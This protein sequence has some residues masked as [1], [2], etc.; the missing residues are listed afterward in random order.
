MKANLPAID[1]DLFRSVMRRQAS[2]VTVITTAHGEH[3]HG[4]TATAFSSVCADPPTI[5]IVVNRS[6]R[7]HPIIGDS[8][9]FVVNILA[10][11][12]RAMAERFAGKLDDQF[13][14]IDY[15]VGS[16]SGPILDGAAAHLECQVVS[17][18][19]IETHTLFVGRVVAGDVA[20]ATPLIYH[21]GRYAS[22]AERD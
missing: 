12:Q 14:G 5:V 22:L 6:T 2:C 18:T 11:D 17:R 13:F 3:I 10:N 9:V 1:R 20:D 15:H 4:M 21:D 16:T 7:S 8:G 19:E